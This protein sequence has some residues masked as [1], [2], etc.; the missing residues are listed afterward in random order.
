M[1]SDWPPSNMEDFLTFYEPKLRAEMTAQFV[2]DVGGTGRYAE[3]RMGGDAIE[4]G[5][6]E[7]LDGLRSGDQMWQK[8]YHGLY[9][10]HQEEFEE[11][12]QK[13]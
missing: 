10:E 7:F 1:T 12:T 3:T 8:T 9:G 2:G 5:V 6:Q 4:R 11:H 13:S